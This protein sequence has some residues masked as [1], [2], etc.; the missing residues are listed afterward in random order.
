VLIV[1]DDA[2]DVRVL[3]KSLARFIS[4]DNVHVADDGLAALDRLRGASGGP[5]LKRPFL[6]LLDLKMPRMSGLEFLRTIRADAAL[7]NCVVIALTTSDDGRDR[8]EAYRYWV[9]AY[10]LKPRG[11]AEAE[12]ITTFLEQYL[13]IVLLPD[14]GE[15]EE[16]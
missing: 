1:D 4:D 11:K 14:N 16:R 13:R 12:V 10:L 5:P 9:A 15:K 7:G 3:R 8:E 2:I 6:I